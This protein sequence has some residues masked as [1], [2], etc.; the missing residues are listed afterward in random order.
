ME[1]KDGYVH[2][3]GKG[4][5]R[6]AV[7]HI[8]HDGW[9]FPQELMASVCVPEEVFREYHE[10][11]R[12]KDVREL[13]P[14]PW[15][16]LPGIRR[17][18]VSRLLCDVE[19]F[20]GPEEIMEQ[21]GMGFC[22]EKAYDGTVIKRVTDEVKG[23]AREYY[24]RHHQRMDHMCQVYPNIFLLDL[25]SYWDGIV[26]GA[27]LRGSV[28]T[29]DL[30]VGTDPRFT[31]PWLLENVVNRFT[32]A[33]LSVAVNYPYSG[34]FV[35]DAAMQGVMESDLICVMLEFHRRAYLDETGR[36]SA[37]KV[38]RIRRV[39]REIL[40]DCCAWPMTSGMLLKQNLKTT[41][42]GST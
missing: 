30:C 41:H 35:P 13:L 5:R 1:M 29:P 42:S 2:R 39:I 31:P 36:K 37:E 25:H 16:S 26:P 21:Y 9:N 22:Y 24:N 19:R 7:F 17:F 28:P 34:C 38:C 8:P 4:K 11:M 40:E 33:G 32:G 27:F 10:R 15:R 6:F 20:I 14:S 23:L 12:D 18:S 3:E